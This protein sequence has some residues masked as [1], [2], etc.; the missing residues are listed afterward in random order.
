[1]RFELNSKSPHLL[2]FEFTLTPNVV[3]ENARTSLGG[4]EAAMRHLSE[5]HMPAKR[6]C[7][8]RPNPR[9]TSHSTAHTTCKTSLHEMQW[10]NR[11]LQASSSFIKQDH[12]M[13]WVRRCSH[14]IDAGRACSCRFALKF[15]F[16]DQKNAVLAGEERQTELP[17]ESFPKM[18][19]LLRRLSNTFTSADLH[20][21]HRSGPS[22]SIPDLSRSM[23]L[24]MSI[25]HTL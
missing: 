7:L 22:S 8:R 1:M 20:Q 21:P 10:R 6:L 11:A 25:A 19:K 3:F 9:R 24:A 5:P 18:Y 23:S 16:Q 15:R 2:L 13:K 17:Y 14:L 12:Q 4:G